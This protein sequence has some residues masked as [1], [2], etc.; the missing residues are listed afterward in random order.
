ALFVAE[1]RYRLTTEILLFPVTGFGL[2]RL[3]TWVAALTRALLGR[4]GAPSPSVVV[5]DA[6][7]GLLWTG[8]ILG[9]VILSATLVVRGGQALRDS[10]R[11]AATVWH[12]NGEP[13]PAFWKKTGAGVSPVHG[14]ADGVTLVLEAGRTE[15]VAEIVLPD[16]AGPGANGVADL[17]ATL[18]WQGEP[19]AS[20]RLDL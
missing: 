12:V 13:K 15:A 18:A 19:D 14:L 1:P 4:R 11:W 2:A 8:A 20:A 7:A 3:G 6:R 17:Q 10:H 9:G 5:R 16:G